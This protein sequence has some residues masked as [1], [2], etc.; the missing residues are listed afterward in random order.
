MNSYVL[1][2]YAV[3]QYL[4]AEPG[5]ERIRELLRQAREGKVKLYM[6]LANFV[7]TY[8][9]IYQK[10][11]EIVAGNVL[12]RLRKMPISF[13]AIDDENAIFTGR[14]KA[15]KNISFADSFVVGCALQKKGI[16]LTGDPEFKE[17][18]DIVQIEWLPEKTKSRS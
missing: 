8:Y 4:K 5:G 12:A 14:C 1:D 13:V 17:V 10:D 3:I 11:G 9:A 2:T 7:E 16:V 6:H 18:T 15:N